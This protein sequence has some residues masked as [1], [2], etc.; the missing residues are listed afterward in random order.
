M[1]P[2]E[3]PPVLVQGTLGHLL[4]ISP[5]LV[6]DHVDE[7]LE[8]DLAVL[9]DNEVNNSPVEFVFS[10]LHQLVLIRRHQPDKVIFSLINRLE[11]L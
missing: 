11:S 3:R 9:V 7:V 2:D 10:L 1:T 4:A 6:Q 5:G 8:G